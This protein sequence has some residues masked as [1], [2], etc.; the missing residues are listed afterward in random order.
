ML[1]ADVLKKL[2]LYKDRPIQ[3]GLSDEG[4]VLFGNIDNHWL[5]VDGDNL[6]EVKSNTSIENYGTATINQ[7]Q[8]PFI[9]TT[10]SMDN[11]VYVRSY[12]K[13]ESGDINTIVGS[14]TPVGT[15]DSIADIL[16][17]IEGNSVRKAM[18]PRGNLN[19]PDV[20][21][22]GAYGAFKGSVISTDSD[23]IPQY[24]KNDLLNKE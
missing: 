9:I 1:K 13:N 23:G 16:K 14:L 15:D 18:S 8:S 17:A 11:I 10:V 24:L 12:I 20:S 21:T 6:V 22:K 7:Q 4:I 19:T 2:E 3:V 5:F